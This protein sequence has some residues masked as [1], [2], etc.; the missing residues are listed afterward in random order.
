MF[1]LLSY[2]TTHSLSYLLIQ[3][4]LCSDVCIPPREE[5]RKQCTLI[6]TLRIILEKPW[7]VSEFRNWLYKQLSYAGV[8]VL[9][10][11]SSEEPV[12]PSFQAAFQLQG[13]EPG[14][15]T[16]LGDVFAYSSFC[17]TSEHLLQKISERP[18]R[19]QTM[20]IKAILR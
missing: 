14:K 12:G 8:L 16:K 20:K 1:L 10:T 13:R 4:E 17:A 7:K 6:W 15:D 9:Y 19:W 11:E 5:L 18:K 3:A 2:S